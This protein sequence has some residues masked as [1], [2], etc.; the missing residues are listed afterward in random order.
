MKLEE[1]LPYVDI[2]EKNPDTEDQ[3]TSLLSSGTIR[4]AQVE[5][6]LNKRVTAPLSAGAL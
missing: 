2:M 5:A 1:L 4:L 6:V 3:I